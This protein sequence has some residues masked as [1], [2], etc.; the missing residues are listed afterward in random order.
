MQTRTLEN[1][2]LENEDYIFAGN[3]TITGK[4]QLT[5]SN[6]IVSGNLTFD[7]DA[8]IK[9]GDI[10]CGSIDSE[11]ISI[12]DG[13]I[14]V[15]GDANFADIK[16]DGN[17]EVGGDSNACSIYCFNY[18]VNGYSNSISITA[19]QDVYILGCNDSCDIKAR[20]VL[21]GGDC[22]FNGYG[23]IAKCFECGGEIEHCSSMSVG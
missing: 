19:M 17:V 12:V 18:L 7:S 22:N 21:V 1:L 16:S 8:Q 6:L 9:G 3:L 14:Y 13:D 23:L 2:I 11:N 10:S 15:A 4:V 20:N 5:N